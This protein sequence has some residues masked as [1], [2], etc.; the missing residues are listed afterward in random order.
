MDR[1]EARRR[2]KLT[3]AN[4]Q[5]ALQN[6]RRKDMLL[7][8]CVQGWDLKSYKACATEYAKLGFD[9][10]AIGGLVPRVSDFE[11]LLAIVDA[12]RA[13]VPDKRI[14][15]F[16][17]GSPKIVE[18]LFRRGV[19]SVDSSAYV[20]LA[21]DGKLWGQP[22]VHLTDASPSERLQ[23]ALCNLAMASQ[24]AMPLSTSHLLFGSRLWDRSAAEQGGVREP[25][26]RYA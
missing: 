8:G 19:Q 9:G 11:G 13:A 7:Y 15:V 2:N 17:L 22:A 21:A 18:A 1:L 25:M 16:G 4:A 14:H 10:V 23:L 24:R 26:L 12:V 5:W 3:V 20:K 6:R